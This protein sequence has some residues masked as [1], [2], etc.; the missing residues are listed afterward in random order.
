[1]ILWAY[2]LDS[3]SLLLDFLIS[4][5]IRETVFITVMWLNLVIVGSSCLS[6]FEIKPLRDADVDAQWKTAIGQ[7]N[8]KMQIGR[9]RT[10]HGAML[11]LPVD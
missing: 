3:T 2:F 8:G 9:V 6:S 7:I 5:R 11:M 10:C 1:M 4:D